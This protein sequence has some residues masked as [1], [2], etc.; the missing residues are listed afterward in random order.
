MTKKSDNEQIEVT[1]WFQ[2]HRAVVWDGY[3]TDPLTGE[4]AKEPSLTKQAHKDECDINNIVK[5]FNATGVL[6][7]L[8]TAEQAGVFTDLPDPFSYQDALNLTIQAQHSFSQL[9]SDIRARFGNDPAQFLAFT[10][11]PANA[12]E[13]IN[14]GLATERPSPTPTAAPTPLN[15]ESVSNPPPK[16]D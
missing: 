10:G 1:G 5:A 6:N 9:P 4:T 13:L 12:Q 15:T 8:K 2:P 14:M 11:D 7:H 16:A 3:V